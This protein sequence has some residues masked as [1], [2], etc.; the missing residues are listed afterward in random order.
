MDQT[1]R[2]GPAGETPTP[3][4]SK[5][6]LRRR[7]KTAGKAP[8]KGGAPVR[9]AARKGPV[10]ARH[11]AEGDIAPR[12]TSGGIEQFSVTEAVDAAHESKAYAV[13]DIVRRALQ[14][15]KGSATESL[16][17]I[18]AGASPDDVQALRKVLLKA[19]DATRT[20][21]RQQTDSELADGW[22]EGGYPTST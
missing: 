11:A 13:A 3:S 17:A 5:A 10:A 2:K 15:S 12:L 22:R 14:D 8:A 7:R 19:G 18:L 4:T 20:A 6:P 9:A 1:T 21:Q 16:E